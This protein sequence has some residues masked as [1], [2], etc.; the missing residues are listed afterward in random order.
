MA[1]LIWKLWEEQKLM[2]VSTETGLGKY[3]AHSRI[4]SGLYMCEVANKILLVFWVFSW[5]FSIYSKF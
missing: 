1:P 2:Y 3:D 5:L 4:E